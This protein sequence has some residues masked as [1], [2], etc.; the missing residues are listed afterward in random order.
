M[1]LPREN[2]GKK[3]PESIVLYLPFLYLDQM[4]CVLKYNYL[5]DP[6]KIILYE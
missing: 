1:M 2:K 3:A 4:L 6:K 5:F